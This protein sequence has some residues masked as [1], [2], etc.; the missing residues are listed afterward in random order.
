M[1]TDPL[2]YDAASVHRNVIMFATSS[3]VP[4]RPTGTPLP[5]RAMTSSIV[6]PVATGPLGRWL[7]LPPEGRTGVQFLFVL[8][9][10]FRV[11]VLVFC[12]A[13]EGG[14]R[15]LLRAAAWTFAAASSSPM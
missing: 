10:D 3:A 12:L 9:G 6:D 11:F 2:Q 7:E 8:L 5:L 15:G 13:G 1:K 14:R 4:Y